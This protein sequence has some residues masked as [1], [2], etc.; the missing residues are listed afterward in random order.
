MLQA[1]LNDLT[2]FL[3]HNPKGKI[4]PTYLA[5]LGRNCSQSNAQ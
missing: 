1:N 5:T 4:I 2:T 3:T